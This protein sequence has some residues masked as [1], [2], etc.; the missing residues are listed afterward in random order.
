MAD[1][2]ET[3]PAGPGPAGDPAAALLAVIDMQPVF[4]AGSPWATPGFEALT[5]PVMTLVRAFSP[6][7]AFTRFVVPDH[8]QGSW[9]DYYDTWRFVTAPEAAPLLELADPWRGLAQH[10]VS[11]PTFS[12]WGPELQGL[13]GA[14]A[15]LVLCGVA[16]DCCVLA[17]A[18]AALDHGARV[19]VVTDATAGVTAQAHAA[20]L[21]LLAGFAPQAHVSTVAEELAGLAVSAR[22]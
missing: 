16:T 10:V 12:K 6:R 17:T 3:A 8:P 19:R 14:S 15:P 11:Q 9:I 18:L 5:D 1:R 4:A 20:A 22:R 2:Q 21:G 7:V 13:L